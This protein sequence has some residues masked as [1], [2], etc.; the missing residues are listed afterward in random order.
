MMTIQHAFAAFSL[1]LAGLGLTFSLPAH[2]DKLPPEQITNW[3][4]GAQ[5]ACND[6]LANTKE[7]GVVSDKAHV[8]Q[9]EDEELDTWLHEANFD[10][11]A[12]PNEAVRAQ[13][14]AKVNELFQACVAKDFIAQTTKS[15][16]AE[17]TVS[18]SL[19]LQLQNQ[20]DTRI[21]LVCGCYGNNYARSLA[22]ALSSTP[23]KNKA[24]YDKLKKRLGREAFK[25]CS[26]GSDYWA[27]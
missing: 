27:K 25:I 13:V 19:Q 4:Q 24:D 23:P 16:M 17:C 10:N 2:A 1:S 12:T 18:S 7:G 9:C 21:Q 3:K 26:N 8:C 11:A 20:S 15:A 5:A 14:G 22:Q 6:A